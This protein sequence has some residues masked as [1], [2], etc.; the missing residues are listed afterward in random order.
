MIASEFQDY[1]HLCSFPASVGS[2]IA[3]I[4]R[5]APPKFQSSSG[6]L[7]PAQL[8][9]WD[10]FHMPPCDLKTFP[11]LNS[12]RKALPS[13][14]FQPHVWTPEYRQILEEEPAPNCKIKVEE[15]PPPSKKAKHTRSSKNRLKKR[16]IC[17]AN[18]EDPKDDDSGESEVDQ[19][20]SSPL[21]PLARSKRGCQK[22][23]INKCKLEVVVPNRPKPWPIP[24]PVI[25]KTPREVSEKVSETPIPTVLRPEAP[26][27]SK[28]SAISAKTP[29]SYKGKARAISASPPPIKKPTRGCWTDM[30]LQLLSTL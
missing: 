20:R 12:L 17:M 25:S 13:S 6:V 24:K 16:L 18:E 28:V 14:T 15:V 9:S 4:A 10:S 11:P 7:T 8:A 2:L 23:S 3:A 19:L 26:Y 22:G 21:V 27:P 29:A 30:E 5:L 1:Y